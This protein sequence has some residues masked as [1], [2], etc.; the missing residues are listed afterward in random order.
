VDAWPGLKAGFD[1]IDTSHDGGISLD[2]LKTAVAQWPQRRA[3]AEEPPVTAVPPKQVA[4]TAG[5]PRPSCTARTAAGRFRSRTARRSPTCALC[6][7]GFRARR[8]ATADS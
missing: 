1:V 4:P 6:A 2:E 5:W 7:T 8:T 3:E